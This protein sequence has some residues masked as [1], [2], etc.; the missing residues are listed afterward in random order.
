LTTIVKFDRVLAANERGDDVGERL[1]EVSVNGRTLAAGMEI[2]LPKTPGRRR[3]RYRF[4]W[5]EQ[6]TN[7]NIILSVYGPMRS[8]AGTPHYR[9][10]NI[11][12]VEIV[13][14]KT[15]PT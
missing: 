3:G 15:R 2:T 1:E 9:L 13:H 4:D 8:R 10:A 5:A 12:A 11:S 7:G 14:D 6:D